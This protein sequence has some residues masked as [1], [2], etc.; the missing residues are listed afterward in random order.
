MMQRERLKKQAYK[1]L[2][3]RPAGLMGGSDSKG[4]TEHPMV[5][6]SLRVAESSA[7]E[8]LLSGSGSGED[9]E[10]A[11]HLKKHSVYIYANI[12]KFG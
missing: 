9:I 6:A 11:S 2:G 10:V 1:F 12:P 5:A 7:I 8:A 4:G 3:E